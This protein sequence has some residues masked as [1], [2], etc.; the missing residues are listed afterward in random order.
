MIPLKILWN[1]SQNYHEVCWTHFSLIILPQRISGLIQA[2][3]QQIYLR[4]TLISS[5]ITANIKELTVHFC[6]PTVQLALENSTDKN[7]ELVLAK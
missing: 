7:A 3:I 4:P 5:T 6:S 1:K 2:I